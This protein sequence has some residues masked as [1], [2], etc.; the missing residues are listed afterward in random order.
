MAQ[1]AY[2]N[3]KESTITKLEKEVDGLKEVNE[4]MSLAYRDLFD[5]ATRNGLL[6]QAPEFGQRL[7]KLE[8]LAKHSG[9]DPYKHD[10]DADL[11]DETYHG[12]HTTHRKESS[13]SAQDDSPPR[14]SQPLWG[15]VIV[16][17]E[18]VG[19]TSAS[20]PS[21]PTHLQVAPLGYEIVAQ[22][23]SQNASFAQNLSYDQ[24][25]LFQTWNQTP[26]PW[27]P[28]PPPQ[29][30][31][32]QELS[33]SRRLQRTALQRA[34]KLVTMK[35]PPPDKMMRVFGFARLFETLEQIRER[36]L[37]CLAATENDTLSYW[38][39]PFSHLGGAGTH[40]PT[41]TAGA[42]GH[43]RSGNPNPLMLPRPK[44]PAPFSIGPFDKRTATI[45]E[46]LVDLGGKIS[47][48]GFDGVF[49]DCDEVELYLLHNGVSIPPL[50]DHCVVEIGEGNFAVA[51]P[52]WPPHGSP[53]SQTTN[54]SSMAS[55]TSMAS[56]TTGSISMESTTSTIPATAT[57]LSSPASHAENLT[58]AS[59]VAEES[60]PPPPP[61]TTAPSA[62]IFAPAFTQPVPSMPSLTAFDSSVTAALSDPSLLAFASNNERQ[63]FIPAAP[64]PQFQC[65]SPPQ[66]QATGRKAWRIDVEKFLDGTY[67]ACLWP[68]RLIEFVGG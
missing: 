36:T 3:R 59:S 46:K 50:A 28:L 10:D 64:A 1:R 17:H 2:R 35:N 23:T 45:R 51:P 11:S 55:L 5:Y 44:E 30:Y 49:W 58:I 43:H 42:S 40:L 68:G 56:A 57:S 27:N 37:A 7:M 15:G 29:N 66:P 12:R 19:E 24:S 61:A 65:V 13:N 52:D 53:Q 67:S 8:A 33:F 38:R 62:D 34:A 18:P 26:S 39:Y 21:I 14:Q 54:P 60:W 41:T 20:A 31:A 63:P 4:Q 32:F 6:D 9:E 47:L 25:N 48:A 16:S 22:P